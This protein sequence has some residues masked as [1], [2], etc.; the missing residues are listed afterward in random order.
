LRLLAAD[1]DIETVVGRIRSGVLNLQPDFQRG[2][3]WSI[4]KK[5]RLIDSVLRD[6]HIPPIHIIQLPESNKTEV[7]DGQQR[8]VAIRDFLDD[9]FLVDGY[10]EPIEPRLVA[11]DGLTYSELPPEWQRHIEQFTLR[12]FRLTDYRADEPGELFYRLNQ[13]VALTTAEQRNAFFGPSRQQVRELVERLEAAGV[14]K[15]FIG[16]SNSRMAYDD[17]V[18][19]VCQAL[20]TRTLAEK[21]TAN[22][23]TERYRSNIPFE[24]PVVASAGLAIDTLASA[25][26]LG[27]PHLRLNKATLFSWLWFVVEHFSYTGEALSA[28]RFSTFVE[29]F[30]RVRRVARARDEYDA[31]PNGEAW[32]SSRWVAILASVYEDRS[33]S[34]VADVASVLFR[35]A[36]LWLLYADFRSVLA[37]PLPIDLPPELEASFV[38]DDPPFHRGHPE[39]FLGDVIEANGWGLQISLLVAP[40][41]TP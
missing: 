29:Y 21:I 14:N 32:L 20:E 41:E 36:V 33:T 24:P 10:I 37:D 13:N 5:Q 26:D 12:V 31:L 39:S 7:L 3:V 17:V 9:V 15:D 1:P 30:E 23:L 27:L 35:N 22:V 25:R 2:E 40:E 28:E 4:G 16:F 8:L 34:R 6:W 38:T 11:I 18:A 19:R